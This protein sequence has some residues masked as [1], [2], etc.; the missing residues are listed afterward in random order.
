MNRNVFAVLSCAAALLASCT[1]VQQTAET[2]D[3]KET[4]IVQ[5][6][7]VAD[8]D[9]RPRVRRTAEWAF[10]PFTNGGALLQRHKSNLTADL[11]EE[12]GADVLLEAQYVYTRTLFGRRSLTVTGYPAT[13]SNFRR[14]TEADLAAL[15]EDLPAHRRKVYNVARPWYKVQDLWHKIH[16]RKAH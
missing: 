4:G 9:V 16:K 11:L 3:L 14:A 12:A 1:T 6:P 2:V 15:R 13:F 5:Y 10:N 8:L 7:T